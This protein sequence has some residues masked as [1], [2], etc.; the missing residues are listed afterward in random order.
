MGVVPSGFLIT[1]QNNTYLRP[2]SEGWLNNLALLTGDQAGPSNIDTAVFYTKPPVIYYRGEFARTGT[3]V[4][5]HVVSLHLFD[6]FC[7]QAPEL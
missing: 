3:S 7:M 5:C 6:I 1:G 2:A 4:V